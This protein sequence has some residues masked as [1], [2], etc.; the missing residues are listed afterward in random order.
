V[1]RFVHVDCVLLAVAVHTRTGWPVVQ[2]AAGTLYRHFPA[3]EDL[4]LAVHRHD[5]QKLV[6]SVEEV[7]A[8]HPPLEAFTTWSETLAAYMRAKHGLGVPA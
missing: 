4:I 2:I 1:E 6:D 3:R 8:A 7:L 5:V